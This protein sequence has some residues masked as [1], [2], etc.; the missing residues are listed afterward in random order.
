MLKIAEAADRRA[1][2][3]RGLAEELRRAARGEYHYS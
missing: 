1:D 3:L 2:L